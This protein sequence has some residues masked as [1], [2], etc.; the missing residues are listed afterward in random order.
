MF[1]ETAVSANVKSKL[2]FKNYQNKFDSQRQIKIH[3]A[4]DLF[5]LIPKRIKIKNKNYF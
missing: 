2:F 5:G 4:A 1:D 3:S